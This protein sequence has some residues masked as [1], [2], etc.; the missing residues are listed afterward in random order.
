MPKKSNIIVFT[1]GNCGHKIRAPETYDGKKGMCPKCKNSVIVSSAQDPP[2]KAAET[3]DN[4]HSTS[5]Q[6]TQAPSEEPA[7]YPEYSHITSLSEVITIVSKKSKVLSL[8]DISV[9]ALLAVN[10]IPLFGVFFFDWDAFLIVFLYC[11]ENIV[12][13]FY[14]ILKMVFVAILQPTKIHGFKFQDRLNLLLMGIPFFSLH[15][16][17][18]A[19]GICVIV[20]DLFDKPESVFTDVQNWS[21]EIRIA[22]LALLLSHGISFVRNFV[23]RREFASVHVVFLMIG[24]YG[25]VFLTFIAL[26]AGGF[27]VQGLGSP[28]PLLVI[29]VVLKTS[30]DLISHLLSHLKIISTHAPV[31]RDEPKS[32]VKEVESEVQNSVSSVSSSGKSLAF[33]IGRLAGLCKAKLGSGKSR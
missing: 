25:R 24:P 17:I 27:L 3:I 1:C 15:F 4:T 12:I 14:N 7:K 19:F 31:I 2:S 6:V 16:G 8:L 28:T 5:E 22:F 26:I 10:T 18:F 23:L 33:R 32:T 30:L 11:S 13:G 9:I 21:T 29:L 20:C